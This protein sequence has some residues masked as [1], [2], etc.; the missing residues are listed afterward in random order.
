MNYLGL[1]EIITERMIIK[2]TPSI[3]YE[4]KPI[5]KQT[6]K[7]LPKFP[8]SRLLLPPPVLVENNPCAFQGNS[9]DQDNCQ[10]GKITVYYMN[11]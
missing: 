9:P 6:T 7:I 8:F 4:E 3:S 1:T 5:I 11:Y 10:G 2:T